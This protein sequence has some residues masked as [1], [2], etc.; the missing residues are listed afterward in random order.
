MYNE[1][2]T[3]EELYAERNRLIKNIENTFEK[4]DCDEDRQNLLESLNGCLRVYFKSNEMIRIL[5]EN[6]FGNSKSF[7]HI[8]KSNTNFTDYDL[9]I[10]ILETIYGFE[11]SEN[12]EILFKELFN[13]Q[14][15]TYITED[16][17]EFLFYFRNQCIYIQTQPSNYA[18]LC[19]E[20]I[21]EIKSIMNMKCY[22]TS[23]LYT[24]TN[25]AY[26]VQE[27]SNKVNKEFFLN[28]KNKTELTNK[29]RKMIS[30]KYIKVCRERNILPLIGDVSSEVL[31]TYGISLNELNMNYYNEM[32]EQ[33]LYL[34]YNIPTLPCNSI[35]GKRIYEREVKFDAESYDLNFFRKQIENNISPLMIVDL[36]NEFEL[37]ELKEKCINE[38][39]NILYMY[40]SVLSECKKI[41]KRDNLRV[42]PF[43]IYNDCENLCWR[44]HYNILC[45]PLV[46]SSVSMKPIMKYIDDLRETVLFKNNKELNDLYKSLTIENNSLNRKYKKVFSESDYYKSVQTLDKILRSNLVGE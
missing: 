11:E 33:S 10:K 45:K 26:G 7:Q 28:M 39:D 15:V 19:R 18:S 43:S 27:H 36:I 3:R 34:I 41:V 38:F 31:R 37:E 20:F 14:G 16:I 21:Q 6:K 8:L 40:L 4:L 13:H 25:L 42:T 17:K 9:S 46:N 5:R 22:V 24:S 12:I 1:L 29:D 35:T 2:L 23:Y 30:Q 44:I 32:I